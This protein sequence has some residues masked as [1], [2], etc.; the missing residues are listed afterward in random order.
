MSTMMRQPNEINWS[1]IEE[2]LRS[3]RD[4]L[5]ARLGEHRRGVYVERE[6]D[7]E[8]AAA[9]EN[10]TKDLLIATLERERKTLA[11]IE[12]ALSRVKKGEYGVC[13]GCGVKIP[14]ARLRALPWARCCIECAA[15]G[16]SARV[17]DR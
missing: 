8:I 12:L 6:P 5:Q 14:A 10:I 9:C 7:D 17:F 11:E 1:V 13:A 15:R 2:Q 4:E 3:E 16:S